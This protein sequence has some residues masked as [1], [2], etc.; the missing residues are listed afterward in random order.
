MKRLWL[1]ILAIPVGLAVITLM[2]ADRLHL[3]NATGGIDP[4]CTSSLPCIEYDNNS[5]G[6]GVRGVSLLGNGLIGFTHSNSTLQ[7]NGKAGVFGSDLSSSG[8]FDSGVHGLSMRGNGVFGDSF[9]SGA[10]GVYGQNDGGG[11]GV[12]GRITKPG[13]GAMLADAGSTGS[14]GLWTQSLTGVGANVVGGVRSL[15]DDFPALSIVGTTAGGAANDLIEACPAG[16]PSSLCDFNHTVF[17]VDSIG[18]VESSSEVHGAFIRSDGQIEA[19]GEIS[20]S[21]NVNI[22]GQYQKN[23][24]C[25][26]GCAAAS[27]TSPGRAVVSYVPTQ[28]L[29]TIDDFGEAMLQNGSAYVRLDSG[30]ANVIDQRASYLVFITPE[31]DSRGLYVTQKSA[32]GFAVHENMGGHSSLAF[33]YRIVAK[34]LG[35]HDQ[36]LP[37]VTLP[38][39]SRRVSAAPRF[40]R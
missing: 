32:Q 3:A 18:D 11:Y 38:K 40:S 30:F 26:V 35:S 1:G 31:G 20:T 14:V 34:P 21:G 15:T 10:S 33:S 29:P 7:S 17:F 39:I 19:F 24:T 6:P 9:G 13:L 36:R 22:S 23:G 16:T 5:S 25:V 8:V 27:P 28:S 37:M 12:A 4:T 2:G